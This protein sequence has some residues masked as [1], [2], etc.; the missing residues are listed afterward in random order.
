MTTETQIMWISMHKCPPYLPDG[1]QHYVPNFASDIFVRTKVQLIFISF[2]SLVTIFVLVSLTKIPKNF[3]IFVIN[4]VIVNKENTVFEPIINTLTT[5]S[6]T[7]TNANV[8][9]NKKQMHNNYKKIKL[10][11]DTTWYNITTI[12]CFPEMAE[13]TVVKFCTQVGYLKS[14]HIDDKSLFTL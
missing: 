9:F 14:Q 12:S 8:K 7:T 3:V 13:A 1:R 11:R 2:Q 6:I 10:S 4:I 5:Q